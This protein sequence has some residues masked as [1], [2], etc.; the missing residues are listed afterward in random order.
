MNLATSIHITS[1]L[2]TLTSGLQENE[3]VVGN[4]FSDVKVY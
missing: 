4:S 2:Q 3:F 1:L